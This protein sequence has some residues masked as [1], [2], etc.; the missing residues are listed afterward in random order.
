MAS[1]H[2]P[3]GVRERLDTWQHL[4]ERALHLARGIDAADMRMLDLMLQPDTSSWRSLRHL[5]SGLVIEAHDLH[6][7]LA[8]LRRTTP[9]VL[10]HR[11]LDP[12]QVPDR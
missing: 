5:L 10:S 2:H 12:K 3:R 7:D 6:Q 1:L 11:S 4:C 8:L 9:S